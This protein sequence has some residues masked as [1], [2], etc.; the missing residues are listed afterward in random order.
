MTSCAKFKYISANVED[1]QTYIE[2]VIEAKYWMPSI[3]E[4][5]DYEEL[6]ATLRIST[7]PFFDK[8]DS[9]GLF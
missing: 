6:L 3:E 9:I 4:I 8:T 5:G 2:K 7:S 1:Y